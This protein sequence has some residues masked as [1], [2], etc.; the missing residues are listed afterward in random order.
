MA[1]THQLQTV[2]KSTQ[3]TAVITRAMQLVAAS[4]LPS[5]K[6]RLEQAAPF[7]DVVED[8]I[9]G[10]ASDELTNHPYFQH[11]SI[12]HKHA[13]IVITSDRGLCGNLN[14]ALFKTFLTHQQQWEES[15]FDSIL[16]VYGKKGLEFFSGR[17][18]ILSSVSGLGETPPLSEMMSLI[19]PILDAY[20]RKE[21]DKVYILS[22][23]HKSTLVQEP[24]LKQILPIQPPEYFQKKPG[25]YTYEPNA[26]EVIE[27]LLNQYVE[28]M[29][30]RAIIENIACEQA[31]RMISMKNATESAENIIEDL[32]LTY[33]K[34]R[35]AIITQEIAEISAGTSAD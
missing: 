31:A 3:Q 7:A 10:Y 13:I 16:S 14:L 12:S 35:Q 15:G 19:S 24:V 5:A 34:V 30:Y 4:R 33:N 22:N 6:K 1:K 17:A 11:S 2:I 20:Y 29:I 27:S 9:Y 23:Q 32:N 8:I 25:S 21:V 26:S 28:S 18:Q